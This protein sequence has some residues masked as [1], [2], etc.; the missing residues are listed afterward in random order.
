MEIIGM[1]MSILALVFS[2]YTH[3]QL[4]HQNGQI[5]MTRPNLICFIGENGKDEPKIVIR[6]LLYCTSSKGSHIQNLYLKMSKGN[7][8]VFFPI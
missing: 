5:K 3:W 1:L 2:I 6:G 4:N 7:S 8:V